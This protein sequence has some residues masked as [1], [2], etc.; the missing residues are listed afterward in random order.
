[1]GY[2]QEWVDVVNHIRSDLDWTPCGFEE[3]DSSDGSDPDDVDDSDGPVESDGSLK[4][5][6]NSG[7]DQQAMTN[8]EKLQAGVWPD[9]VEPRF[10]TTVSHPT[11]ER[12]HPY[13]IHDQNSFL[14]NIS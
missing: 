10:I 6:S 4:D 1:M 9:E 12:F 13:W 14:A 2:Q 7:Q 8:G 11:H 3:S 5:R